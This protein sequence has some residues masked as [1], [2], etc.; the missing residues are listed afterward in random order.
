MQTYLVQYNTN[1]ISPFLMSG[2]KVRQTRDGNEEVEGV[3][4]DRP[5]P[6]TKTTIAVRKEFPSNKPI[7]SI[8]QEKLDKLVPFF[9]F[10]DPIKQ[11]RIES[12]KVDFG[13]DSFWNHPD[14]FLEIENT[15]KEL[16]ITD[17][18]THSPIDHFWFDV[19]KA[20]P[21]FFIDDGTQRRPETMSEVQFIVR[22]KYKS[23]QKL[24]KDVSSLMDSRETIRTIISISRDRKMHIIDQLGDSL[25][26]PKITSDRELEDLIIENLDKNREKRIENGMKFGDFVE[27]VAKQTED[28]FSKSQTVKYAVSKG[29]IIKSGDMY[30]FDNMACGNTPKEAED[31][32]QKP[33]NTKAMTSLELKVNS[34]KKG[35]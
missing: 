31:F 11:E 17:D 19:M 29:L 26:D 13:I 35:K 33:E 15:G 4:R 12:A 23:E 3:F 27:A 21:N 28:Q 18:P 7:I 14:L 24:V 25:Y 9:Q 20:D 8:T 10:I 22:P 5:L 16:T 6:T 34:L 30:Y 1:R 32:F 2:T